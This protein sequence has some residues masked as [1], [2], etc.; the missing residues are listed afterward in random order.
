VGSQRLG[1]KKR[2]AIER[3]TG[4]SLKNVVAHGGTHLKTV[5][6][7]GHPHRHGTYDPKTH[8]V[9]WGNP[10]EHFTSCFI[11]DETCN[12]R[13]LI[14]GQPMMRCMGVPGHEGEHVG[15]DEP[16]P[17]WTDTTGETA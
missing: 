14:P 2:R 12:A 4:L 8:E 17:L 15:E 7:A 13:V 10:H 11:A 1:E 9:T 16:Y 3:A 5:V 6:T